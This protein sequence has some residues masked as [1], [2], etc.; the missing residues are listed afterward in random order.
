[1]TRRPR[2]NRSDE[3]DRIISQATKFT[4]SF[5]AAGLAIA[6]VGG[7]FIGWL[8]RWAG[9]PFLRTWLIA[10]ALIILPGLLAGIWKF[11]RER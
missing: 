11:F 8:L 10:T 6:L 1:V 5:L 4:L 2:D 7:A 9:Q 3:R